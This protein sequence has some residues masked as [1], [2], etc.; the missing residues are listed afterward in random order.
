VKARG[1]TLRQALRTDVSGIQRVRHSVKENRLTSRVI[2]D[3]EVVDAI[4][5]SGRGWVA[6]CDNTV[7]GFAIGNAQN[8]NIWALFVDPEYEA[9]GLGRLL[10]D[11]MVA[12][13]WSRGLR[14]LWL[15]T[16]P[17][18]RAQRFYERAGWQNRGLLP[19]GEILFELGAPGRDGRDA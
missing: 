11:A 12:W 17:A 13:L 1:T 16:Q 10:H 8:G 14:G 4:E 7:V 18:T 9:R 15:T 2:G 5:R 19:S 6:E 3:A